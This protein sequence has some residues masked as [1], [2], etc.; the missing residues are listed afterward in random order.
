[1][2][3]HIFVKNWINLVNSLYF[4]ISKDYTEI[5]KN[6]LSSEDTFSKIANRKYLTENL[7]YYN[8]FSNFSEYEKIGLKEMFMFLKKNQINLCIS[9][10]LDSIDVFYMSLALVLLSKKDNNIKKNI[11]ETYLNINSSEFVILESIADSYMTN[12]FKL[13]LI[14]NS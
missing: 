8:K 6:T 5:Q 13:L 9:F 7:Q 1:M 10:F 11:N 14:K 12:L 4:E 3:T 2:E